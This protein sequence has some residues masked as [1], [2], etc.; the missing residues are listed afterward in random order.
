MQ[1]SACYV[2]E[3]IAGMRLPSTE[4]AEENAH[5]AGNEEGVQ[6]ALHL[7]QEG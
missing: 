2:V 7:R 3:D 5:I 4:V 1:K 6:D